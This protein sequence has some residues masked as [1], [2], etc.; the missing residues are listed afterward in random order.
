MANDARGEEGINKHVCEGTEPPNGEAQA[1]DPPRYRT[2]HATTPST[3]SSLPYHSTNPNPLTA[4]L[5]LTTTTMH[6]RNGV[7]LT[8]TTPSSTPAKSASAQS[9][10]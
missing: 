3:A 4:A 9:T 5:S 2:T 1:I 7:P 8:F 10:A 6:S